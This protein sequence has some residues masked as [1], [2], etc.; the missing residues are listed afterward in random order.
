MANRQLFSSIGAVLSGGVTGWVLSSFEAPK[1]YAYLFIFSSILMIV[2]F[3]VFATIDEP[4]KRRVSKREDSFIEFLKNAYSILK[5]DKRL[6]IQIVASL[7][8]YSFLLAMPFVIIQAKE[9]IKLSG[10]LI[11]GFITIQMVGSIFGNFF[12]WRNFGSNYVLMLRVAFVFMVVSFLIAL[13]FHNSYGYMVIFFLFGVGIDGFRN[14]DMN[15][16]IEIAPEAKRPVYVA[17]QSTIVSLGLFFSILGGAILELFG[18]RALYITT[19]LALLIGLYFTSLLKR[20]G[21]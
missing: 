11:G 7:L 12:L 5:S 13:L 8:G 21:V 4:A 15:L 6:Q 10:W 1:S 20:R 16:V 18:Y 14:A 19:I 9:M 2:G 3:L 17:I